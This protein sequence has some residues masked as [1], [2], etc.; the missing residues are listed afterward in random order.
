MKQTY[1]VGAGRPFPQEQSGWARGA[2]NQVTWLSKFWMVVPN[3]FRSSVWPLL[4]VSILVPR[5]LRCYL[6]FWEVYAPL[7]W[8]MRLCTHLHLVPSLRLSRVVPLLP[9]YFF[10][11]RAGTTFL[12]R[13]SLPWAIAL[14]SWFGIDIW[15]WALVHLQGSTWPRHLGYLHP[16]MRDQYPVWSDSKKPTCTVQQPRRVKIL[17]VSWQKSKILQLHL[18]LFQMLKPF[19]CS[20]FQMNGTEGESR[21]WEGDHVVNTLRTGDADLRFYITTVQDGWRKS[22][23]LTRAC[24][25]CTI[26]LIMQY[27]EP[28]SKWFCWRMFIET[29]PHSELIFRHRASCI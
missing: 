22:A 7:G 23:F 27:I 11:A 13:F 21:A 4:L 8:G 12:S 9:V 10:V 2:Q 16:W 19:W 17:T 28:V 25:P 24:F 15:G 1:S 6:D 18:Y 26:H 29:W 5:I 3:M 14:C 20:H